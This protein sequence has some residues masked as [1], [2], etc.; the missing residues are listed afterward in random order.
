MWF[1]DL[2]TMQWFNDVWMKEVFANFMADKVTQGNQA[3]T[4]YDLEVFTWII[5]L[6]PIV[7]TE[8]PAQ[9]LFGN[10]C[11]ICRMQERLY[12]NII[13]HKAPIM[14]RQLERLMGKEAVQKWLA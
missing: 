2:V 13:Y 6:Q 11:Q 8:H 3:T 10:N 4:N 9:T 12:G 14:M 7:L 5:F 1:G